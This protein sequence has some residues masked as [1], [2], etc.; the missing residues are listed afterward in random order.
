MTL[1]RGLA[2]ARTITCVPTGPEPPIR[3]VVVS[4]DRVY[5]SSLEEFLTAVGMTVRCLS[6]TQ[7]LPDP[8]PTEGWADVVLV[9]IH[10][11]DSSEWRL[12]EDVRRREPLVEVVA[13]SSDPVV[14]D[15]VCALR[16]GV[17][18][19]LQY[20]VSSEQLADTITRAMARKRR[21]EGRLR[22]LDEDRLGAAGAPG[23]L[24]EGKRTGP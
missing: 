12:L 14:E 7:R 8:V 11:L 15:A 16:E 19:V 22:E 10:G 4:S 18:S 13:I 1:A 3:V 2:M 9:E 5:A 6:P 21:A 20:P 23:G 17:Y 24:V